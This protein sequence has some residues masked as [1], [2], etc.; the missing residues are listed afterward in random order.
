MRFI[1][2]AALVVEKVRVVLELCRE[3]D[4]VLS[5]EREPLRLIIT[6]NH[7]LIFTRDT[8]RQSLIAPHLL[9]RSFFFPGLANCFNYKK[10][11]FLIPNKVFAD[12]FPC[13]KIMFFSALSTPLA[14]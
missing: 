12:P 8:Q 9:N 13:L 1:F 10:S 6:R 3:L 2:S 11:V 4:H 7:Q 14:P 5:C